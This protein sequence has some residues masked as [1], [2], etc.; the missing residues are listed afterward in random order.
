M[1][2]LAPGASTLAPGGAPA[3]TPSSP[4]RVDDLDAPAGAA[5]RSAGGPAATT[6]GPTGPDGGRAGLRG[7]AGRLLRRTWPELAALA[8]AAGVFGWQA[9]T[10][11]PWRDEGATMVIA[12]RP[13][14]EILDLVRHLDLVH[15]TY[16]FLVHVL[17]VV[18]RPAILGDAVPAVRTIS[19]VA[20]AL[21][22]LVLVRVGRR[23]GSLQVGV[24]A[25]LALVAAPLASRYAQ[26][27]RSYAL[28]MLATTVSALLLLRATQARGPRVRRAWAWYAV[29]LGVVA[30]L[31][32]IA[33]LVLLAHAVYVRAFTAR[34][35]RRRWLVATAAGV[36]AVSPFVVATFLQRGQVDWLYA[37]SAAELPGFWAAQYDTLWLLVA[38]TAAAVLL[39]A[40]PGRPGRLDPRRRLSP[41]AAARLGSTNARALVL[42]LAW[43]VLPTVALWAVS[44]AEPLYTWRYVIFTL[45]GTALVVGSLATALRPAGLVVPVLVLGLAGL[46]MQDVYRDP[47]LGH[48]EDM[49]S[50][51]EFVSAHAR[52]GDAV[53]WVPGGPGHMRTL[54]ELYPDRYAGLVDVALDRTGAATATITGTEKEPA[55]IAQAVKKRKRVWLISVNGALGTQADAV[56]REKVQLLL[57]GYRIK[58]VDIVH[59]F[60]VT[61]WERAAAPKKKA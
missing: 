31:N 35:V 39:V 13:A 11:S 26:E 44:Q 9:G 60:Q 10:P 17:L 42:G 23:L 4:P 18:D 59:K 30:L 48:A 34:A 43:A 16:Y 52:K 33:L 53:L 12:A 40:W 3:R 32:V 15:A 38:V 55:Q 61:L 2:Q 22:A 51:G 46:H 1:H 56:D 20:A 27:A 36:G 7:R 45:P 37:P 5:G 28:V 24:A 41:A 14:G 8:L 19:V 58:R 47:H 25:A 50:V 57:D 29:S 21:A 6:G 49:A 54:Q